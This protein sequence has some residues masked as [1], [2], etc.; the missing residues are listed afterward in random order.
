MSK[1][2]CNK[3]DSNNTNYSKTY[4][5]LSREDKMGL[6]VTSFCNM[7]LKTNAVWY[8]TNVGKHPATRKEDC[9]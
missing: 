4:P 9:T 8:N 2:Q 7:L 3:T 1:V 5:I 6:K